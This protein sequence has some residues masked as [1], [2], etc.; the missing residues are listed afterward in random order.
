[1]LIEIHPKFVNMADISV[2]FRTLKK[3]LLFLKASKGNIQRQWGGRYF[4]LQVQRHNFYCYTEIFYLYFTSDRKLNL[5]NTEILCKETY[6]FEDFFSSESQVEVFHWILLML[7]YNW[8]ETI[9]C[10]WEKQGLKN[11]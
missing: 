2:T 4:G 7:I 3:P 9:F 10:D 6:I 11:A 1:M 8:L 5:L